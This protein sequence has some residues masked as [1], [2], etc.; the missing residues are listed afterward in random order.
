MLIQ[1]EMMVKAAPAAPKGETIRPS[2]E[3]PS[4]PQ[5]YDARAQAR[6]I[7]RATPAGA[8]ATI[9]PSEGAPFATLVSVATD[10]DGSPILLTSA[11]SAHSRNMQ[12]DS[13]VS[14][15]LATRGKGDP[16]AHPRLTLTGR[17]MVAEGDLRARLR[18]RFL[19]RHP[20]AA[21]Y[22]D[23]ADFSFWRIEASGAHFN[24]GFAKAA[25]FDWSDL[26]ADVADAQAL[27]DAEAEALAHLNADHADALGLYARVFARE[28]PAPWR[29]QGLDPEGLDLG[30]GERTARVD[31]PGRVANPGD[32]RRILVD[33][34]RQ[35]RSL[36]QTAE[37]S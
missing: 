11:L 16:L 15:L 34:A 1:E 14:L 25:Q 22:V 8:L 10:H 3:S 32:L 37:G 23:F 4:E 6:R 29:A 21:L 18:A 30:A 24:G 2:I 36:A 28:E 9:D 35:A 27:I 17:A 5:G 7:L 33:L 20:K 12:A 19:A 31:F 26:R 13:R